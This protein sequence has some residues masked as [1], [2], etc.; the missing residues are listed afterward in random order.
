VSRSPA[1]RRLQDEVLEAPDLGALTRILTR[2]LPDALG[3]PEATLLLWNRRLDSFEA[4]SPGE[5]RPRPVRP[6]QDGVPAPAARFLLADGEVLETSGAPGDG[7]LV[8]LMARSGLVGMLVLGAAPGRRKKKPFRHREAGLLSVVA[9]R[10]ALA[11][12][13]H[14]YQREVIE[15]E[16]MAALGAM[17]GMLAHDF[18]GPMTVIRGYAETLAEPGLE[19][20][21]IARR[22]ELIMEMVD[23][24]Q[25]M[26]TDT[27]DFARD[28]R[29]VA[30]RSLD[31]ADLV[32]TIA[33]DLAE[34]VPSLELVRDFRV[35]RGTAAMVDV[36]KVRRATGNI[37][38]NARDAM[39]GRGR[40]H[41]SAELVDGEGADGPRLQIV[42][43]DEGP[44]VPAEIRDRLFEPFV[45]RGKKG[46]TG[47]GLAVARRF[48]EDHG[49][50][51][52]LLPEAAGPGARFRIL[53]PL[54]P[55][56]A[57]A[58]P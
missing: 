39:G 28:G 58:A 32:A 14:L 24:L 2:T 43:A 7:V 31:A 38:A 41:V 45:T 34:Q 26:T 40:L 9:T 46:G 15:S 50:T 16:R 42:L 19:A 27:L 21:E 48:V 5:T 56:A 33:A 4:L 52:E 8:P 54:Q 53:L 37:A 6:G 20:G 1:L 35:P 10:A 30:R 17:A 18:R 49:G 51:L 29:R 3:I 13:N 47:L 12:E 11:L 22:A 23:R 25:R 36:D 57:E 44:G 55:P